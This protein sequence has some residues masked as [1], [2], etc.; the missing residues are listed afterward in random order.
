MGLAAIIIKAAQVKFQF[1]SLLFLIIEAMSFNIIAACIDIRKTLFTL[2][3]VVFILLCVLLSFI[4]IKYFK[5][6]LKTEIITFE[7]IKKHSN[8]LHVF[9]LFI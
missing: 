1:T 9:V 2:S 7:T 4:R 5:F 8:F 3:L 6:L